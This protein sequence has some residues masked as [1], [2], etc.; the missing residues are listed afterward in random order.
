M[1]G[2]KME[3]AKSLYIAAKRGR[4]EDIK[5]LL[6]LKP[7]VY[8]DSNGLN[9]L[10]HAARRDHAKIIQM[11]IKQAKFSVDCNDKYGWTPLHW[12]CWTGSSNSVQTL[13]GLKANVNHVDK[14]NHARSI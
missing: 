12:A 5:K 9:A 3:I 10:H 11:L 13:L 8:I 6:D 1:D 14:V 4:L 2:E 7:L